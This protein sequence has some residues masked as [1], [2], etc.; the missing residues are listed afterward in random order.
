MTRDRLAPVLAAVAT[1]LTTWSLA[2]VVDGKE[3]Q[4]P[5]ILLILVVMVVGMGARAARFPRA[6]VAPVQLLA[7][8]VVLTAIFAGESAIAGL[9]PGPAAIERLGQVVVDGGDTINRYS[10]PVPTSHGISLILAIGVLSIAVLVDLLVVGLRAP[11]AAGIPLLALYAVPAAVVPTGLQWRYFVAA[12]AGWLLLL[13]HDASSRVLRWGRLLPRWGTGFGASRQTFGNDTAAMAATGRRVGLAAI[14]L[15]VV[16]PAA[17]PGV[18]DGLLTT[19]SSGGQTA[20]LNGLTVINP[21]LTLRDNLAPRRNIEVL[22]YNTKQADVQPLRIVTDDSFDGDSWKPGTRDVSRRN[23]ASQGLP[24]APGLSP[25]VSQSEYTMR[26]EVSPS[27]DQDFL[28]LPYPTRR[29]DIKGAWLYDASSLNVIG[30]GE[31]VRGKNYT[32]TYLAVRP[33]VDQLRNAPVLAPDIMQQFTRLPRSLPDVVAQTARA[34][35]KGTT[36]Q[37]DQAMALQEWFRSG[38]KFTYST[39]APSDSGGDAVAAFLRDRRGFCVQFSSAMAVMAR[40]LGIPS[41]IGVG[42]L[43]GTPTQDD[44]W[45]VKLTDAHAWPELYFQNV[46]WVRFEPTP[47]SRTGSA[48]SWAQVGATVGSGGVSSGTATAGTGATAT[49]SVDPRIQSLADAEARERTGEINAV[50]ATVDPGN[51]GLVRAVEVALVVLLLLAAALLT[52]ASAWLGRRRRRRRA[53][54]AGRDVEASWADLH[55]QVADL[56]IE[57][58]VSLTPRQV[59]HRLQSAATLGEDSQAALSR[60]STTVERARYARPG[61]AV[62]DLQGDVRTVV[63]AVSATRPRSQR[64][65]AV[66]YPSSGT[67]R[68]TGVGR[69]LGRFLGGWDERIARATHRLRRP[70]IHKG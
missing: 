57:L 38:G 13:A 37:Y 9:L 60:I 4:G 66:L 8:G 44:W 25:D 54:A 7:G 23:R 43:P 6:L 21:V 64:L 50:T 69:R 47:A 67:S 2:P 10:A 14:V 32:A 42:F 15:A 52:P 29:V 1:L 56:G 59:D 68:I 51:A 48:P 63:R 19:G 40:T 49:S 20:G 65:R 18:S 34:V 41:R 28:P 35:T 70:R 39:D 53:A 5:C 33:T 11:A 55:E 31:T 30:D 36:N 58:P 27:L 12:A 22:R 62:D 45:S 26:I 16:I 46:G 17:L 61:S 24:T 3:W